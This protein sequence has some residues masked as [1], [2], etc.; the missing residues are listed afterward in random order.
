ML[1]IY[2][3]KDLFILRIKQWSLV[4]SLELYSLYNKAV[5]ELFHSNSPF[6]F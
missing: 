5:L 4:N 2:G 6:F 1:I 3:Q